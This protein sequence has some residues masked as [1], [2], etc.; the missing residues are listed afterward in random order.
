MPRLWMQC[1]ERSRI[2]QWLAVIVAGPLAAACGTTTTLDSKH[3]VD[4]ADATHPDAARP[5]DAAP[6]PAACTAAAETDAG[7]APPEYC[8]PSCIWKMMRDCVP[9]PAAVCHSTMKG[10]ENEICDAA[11]CW[12]RSERPA[13]SQSGQSIEIRHAGELCV[14]VYWGGA[15]PIHGYVYGDRSG[16]VAILQGDSATCGAQADAPSFTLDPTRPECKPW[17]LPPMG[18]PLP[19]IPCANTIPGPCETMP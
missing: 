12:S 17:G 1:A 7:S 19:D 4:H 13:G 15:S 10:P 5:D 11:D 2:L 14:G 16:A 3:I 9:P 18:P 8:I 6:A